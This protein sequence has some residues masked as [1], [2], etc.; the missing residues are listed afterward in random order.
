MG[1][2]VKVKNNQL[3]RFYVR[4]LCLNFGLTINSSKYLDLS[5]NTVTARTIKPLLAGVNFIELTLTLRLVIFQCAYIWCFFFKQNKVSSFI[6]NAGNAIL[7]QAKTASS[8]AIKSASKSVVGTAI[9]VI[10]TDSSN[11]VRSA[12]TSIPNTTTTTTTHLFFTTFFVFCLSLVNTDIEGAMSVT[13]KIKESSVMI[14]K[15]NH[16]PQKLHVKS[17]PQKR[18]KSQKLITKF[19]L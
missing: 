1:L 2:L 14:Q 16:R 17:W 5:V 7:S 12:T 3:A 4:N 8:T 6:K 15:I 11:K 13:K 18:K 9:N 19:C 10:L